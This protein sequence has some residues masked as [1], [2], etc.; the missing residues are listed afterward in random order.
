MADLEKISN[1]IL[2]TGKKKTAAKPKPNK[3]AVM[4]TPE[5][6]ANRRKGQQQGALRSGPWVKKF[7][8]LDPDVYD[9]AGDL[10]TRAPNQVKGMLKFMR[11]NL[12]EIEEAGGLQGGEIAS[13]SISEGFI[14]SKIN[15]PSALFAYYRKLMETFGLILIEQ[16]E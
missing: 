3:D 8:S 12:E 6:I 10:L 13:R 9:K 4:L 15:P 2:G 1:E 11:Q 16:G 14:A 7:Y 5:E